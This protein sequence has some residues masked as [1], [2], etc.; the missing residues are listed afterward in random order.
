MTAI[1]LKIK[2]FIDYWQDLSLDQES[3]ENVT[4]HSI[5]YNPKELF[6]EFANEIKRSDG[7]SSKQQKDFLRNKI[8]EFAKIKLKALAFLSHNLQIMQL[9]FN[10][11]DNTTYL[12]HLL[13][14]AE[15]AMSNFKLG[16]EVIKE[17]ADILTDN[18]NID[19]TKIK[20]LVNLVQ[21]ELVH[22]KYSN[23]TIRGT[24]EQIFSNYQEFDSNLLFTY[25]FQHLIKYEYTGNLESDQNK[26]NNKIKSYMDTITYK[27]RILSISNLFNKEEENL[28][29]IFQSNASTC[30]AILVNSLDDSFTKPNA[31]LIALRI[32]NDFPASPHL[33]RTSSCKSLSILK[34][35]TSNSAIFNSSF[36]VY[37]LFFKY[38]FV[39]PHYI[40]INLITH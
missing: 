17:L 21:F 10:Q 5:V 15:L 37:N 20:H 9:Q 2:Y 14:M 3:I 1:E 40:R 13:E 39:I 35:I 33:S 31:F 22:K 36:E 23:N 11:K 38:Y 27:E 6:K 18:S 28:R 30:F 26:Y 4:I 24:I 8:N 7:K 12:L 34:L 19:K 16:H 25:Y 29:F 32:N